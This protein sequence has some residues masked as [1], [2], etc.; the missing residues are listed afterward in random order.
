MF[1]PFIISLILYFVTPNNAGAGMMSDRYCLLL[2]FFGFVWIVSRIVATKLNFILIGI[3]MVLHFSLLFKHHNG[4]LVK[5]NNNAITIN[6]A[7]KY[8]SEN[9]IVLPI[10]LSK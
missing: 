7:A 2:Y 3:V 4:A 6:K 8:I 1:I 10:N 5:L 9:K